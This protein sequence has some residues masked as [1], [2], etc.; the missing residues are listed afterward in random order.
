MNKSNRLNGYR[1]PYVVLV[2]KMVEQF[3]VDLEEE[4]VETVKPHNEITCT[5]M[6]K[7]ELL[8]M[9]DDH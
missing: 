7:I 2:S 1:V 8:K 9:I 5:I 6:H 4:L 3:G